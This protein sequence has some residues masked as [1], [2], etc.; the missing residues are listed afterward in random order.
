MKV[1][2]GGNIILKQVL[3]FE[4]RTNTEINNPTK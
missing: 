2:E 1:L 3:T 4:A